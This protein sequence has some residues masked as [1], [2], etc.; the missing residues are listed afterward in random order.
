[1][2]K[3]KIIFKKLGMTR[4]FDENNRIYPITVLQLEKTILVDEKTIEKDGYNYNILQY[5]PI[6]KMPSDPITFE[7]IHK[8]RAI[9]IHKQ[10]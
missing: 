9:L 1:M 8:D 10:L 3:N 7:P 6:E 4:L 5:L 2:K